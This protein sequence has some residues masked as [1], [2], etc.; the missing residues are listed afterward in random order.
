LWKK[1]NSKKKFKEGGGERIG[2]K[3]MTKRAHVAE[4][5]KN[6]WNHEA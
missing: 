2:D 5:G 1:K 6:S 4:E 3:N